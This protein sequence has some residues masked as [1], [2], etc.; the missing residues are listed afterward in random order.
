MKLNKTAFE[1]AKELIK[2]GKI[3]VED[4][5]DGVDTEKENQ[6]I[7]KEGW[8]SYKKWYLGINED[9]NEE[10][11]ARYSY[12]FTNDF[13]TI[14][15]KGVIAIKQRSSQYN[16]K[17]IFEAS[18]ELLEMIDKVLEVVD[19]KENKENEVSQ[20]IQYNIVEKILVKGVA[21][22]E[23]KNL[24]GITI[25]IKD[26]DF[27]YYE[28]INKPILF[29]HN[30]DKVIGNAI[31]IEKEDKRI[32]F[33]G[34]IYNVDSSFYL[35]K[36]K[37]VKGVSVGLV[38]DKEKDKWVLV[39]LSITPIPAIETAQIYSSQDKNK[40]M[41]YSSGWI[42]FE[43]ERDFEMEQEKQTN[44]EN[45]ENI[46]NEVVVNNI[47]DNQDKGVVYNQNEGLEMNVKIDFN[48]KDNERIKF[49]TININ[50]G[51]VKQVVKDITATPSILTFI[52]TR[53]MNTVAEYV[54]YF[55]DYGN[56]Y[57]ETNQLD[58]LQKQ[59]TVIVAKYFY[60]GKRIKPS[61]LATLD[62]EKINTII[63]NLRK[64]LLY[65]IEKTI[66]LGD[67]SGSTEP[68]NYW[69]GLVKL[70]TNSNN[71]ENIS[72]VNLS[73]IKKVLKKLAGY[74]ANPLDLVAIVDIQ[75]FDAITSIPEVI[76]VDKFG[77]DAYVKTGT[78]ASL[79]GIP[80]YITPISLTT[81][82][83]G[84]TTTKLI[85]ANKNL[86]TIGI[87][88]DIEVKDMEMVDGSV[89]IISNAF[90]GFNGLGSGVA[91]GNITL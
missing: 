65:G 45:I 75:G 51:D 47:Q 90:V 2:Q 30:S 36:E 7:E 44:I 72:T 53:K 14:H 55:A 22:T 31:K 76:T 91:V 38:R 59:D 11:K 64:S 4:K 6:Y 33:E 88:Q 26:I 87:Y 70:A 34:Y 18:S 42:Y 9:A 73:N 78:V 54:S 84:D 56:V 86:L 24:N 15:R 80:V 29:N 60:A 50:W 74:G 28:R 39:E 1:Y 25:P 49:A 20:D 81:T 85:I 52:G 48:N 66:L 57:G 69:D 46:E 3:T 83:G 67:T 23:D 19:K 41:Y 77:N 71:V 17:D 12:P 43:N 82:S 40:N 13:E 61:E 32:T 35:I 63:E 62:N 5:W 37:V 21:Y 58:T 68:W 10:T 16:H 89:A 27:T 79:L 8:D